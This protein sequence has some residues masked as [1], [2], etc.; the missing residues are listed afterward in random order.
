MPPQ[1]AV[2]AGALAGTLGWNYRRSLRGQTTISM[3]LREHPVAFL[4]GWVGLT[5][6]LV[7]HILTD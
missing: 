6:W 2:L 1:G 3:L 7:P 5:L 4:V